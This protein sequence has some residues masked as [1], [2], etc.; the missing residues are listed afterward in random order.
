MYRFSVYLEGEHKTLHM[1]KRL[2]GHLFIDEKPT[3]FPRVIYVSLLNG[4]Q[5][6]LRI[7]RV[8]IWPKW[9]QNI[10]KVFLFSTFNTNAKTIWLSVGEELYEFSLWWEYQTLRFLNLLNNLCL[11]PLYRMCKNS[12]LFWWCQGA[13]SF[14]ITNWILHQ[15]PDVWGLKLSV[16]NIMRLILILSQKWTQSRANSMM[17]VSNFSKWIQIFC[18]FGLIMTNIKRNPAETVKRHVL[19]VL[20]Y[21]VGFFFDR[22]GSA[23]YKTRNKKPV[24]MLELECSLLFKRKIAK[25]SLEKISIQSKKKSQ[26]HNI[27]CFSL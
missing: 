2:Y 12:S 11:L 17:F 13:E 1:V 9:E 27:M 21:F 19:W 24:L 16:Q 15:I 8:D 4:S 7:P 18:R 5:L 14:L 23:V 25:G 3:G 22:V 20:R 6:R 26:D 10:F